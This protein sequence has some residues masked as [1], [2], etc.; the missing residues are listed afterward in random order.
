MTKEQ[1][2]AKGSR[3][4]V[5]Y[6]MVRIVRIVCLVVLVSGGLILSDRLGAESPD[7]PA[8]VSSALAAARVEAARS[9]KMNLSEE[10][11]RKALTAEQ[12][13]I[14]RKKGT[15]RAF[16]GRYWDSKDSGVFV[17]A[18]C[19]NVLFSSKT[20]FKSGTG[21]PSFHSPITTAAV[22]SEADS[23]LFMTRTEVL[24]S[25]CEGHLGHVFDDGPP[26]TG[27]RY[28][29]NSASLQFASEGGS[30]TATGASK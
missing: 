19:G 2:E 5:G 6:L 7:G 1:K 30:S 16:T 20:K 9:G 29:I 22:R 12:F 4:G 3:F 21:W 11:W 26:P 27:L 15:E 8:S 24:C 14:L 25:R 23:S 10:E 13:R 17:C 18:G 28:C